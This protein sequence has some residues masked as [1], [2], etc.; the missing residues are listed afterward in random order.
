MKISLIWKRLLA[1]LLTMALI[2]AQTGA[3]IAVS[4]EGSPALGGET[5]EPPV[6][7]TEVPQPS[8]PLES[9]A[10]TEEVP[11]QGGLD[12]EVV[13]RPILPTGEPSGPEETSVPE[14]V[15][16]PDPVLPQETTAPAPEEV[17]PETETM[18]EIVERPLLPQGT[19]E[20]AVL[21]DGELLPQVG[22]T[23]SQLFYR[24]G[25][26]VD[27]ELIPYDEYGSRYIQLNDL[28]EDF[29][30]ET[31]ESTDKVLNEEYPSHIRYGYRKYDSCDGPGWEQYNTVPYTEEN[32]SWS[33]FCIFPS[34]ETMGRVPDQEFEGWYLYPAGSAPSKDKGSSEDIRSWRYDK[35]M[36]PLAGILQDYGPGDPRYSELYEK[37][38][39]FNQYS[40]RPYSD[41][42]GYW[43]GG[44]YDFYADHGYGTNTGEISYEETPVSIVG[45][46]VPS[47]QS[48]AAEK[49]G[50]ILKAAGT[51]AALPLYGDDIS[52]KVSPKAVAFSPEKTEYWLRVAADV[53]AL[54]L[55]FNSYELYY[56]YHQAPEGKTSPVTVTNTFGETVDAYTEDLSQRLLPEPI[57]YSYKGGTF[58][59][60]GNSI[61]DPAHSEWNVKGITLTQSAG[62]GSLYNDIQVTVTSPS[63]E[64]E[65]TYTFHVQR[66][67][68]PT[69][70]RAPGNTPAGM[71]Q[72]DVGNNWGVTPEE[73]RSNK[74]RARKFFEEHRTFDF[75]SSD[76]MYPRDFEHNQGGSIFRGIYTR[77]AWPSLPA[78]MD[79][80]LDPT[81][82]VVYQDAAFLDPG[83]TVTD[84]E[85]NQITLSGGNVTRTLRLREQVGGLSISGVGEG[86]GVTVDISGTVSAAGGC[87]QIDLRGRNILP[88]IYTMEYAYTDPISGKTYDSTGNG[89][90]TTAGAAGKN[91]FARTVVVLPIPGDVDMDGA[92]TSADAVIL[93]R[94]VGT[95]TAGRVTLNGRDLTTDKVAALFAYRVCDQDQNG[96]L[97]DSDVSLLEQLPSPKQSDLSK[98]DYYYIPLPTGEAEEHYSRQPLVTQGAG[99]DKA[100]ISMEYLGKEQGVRS[101]VGYYNNPS[102]PWS[103]GSTE[104]QGVTLNDTFWLGIKLTDGN[105]STGL[106]QNVQTFTFSLTYDAKYVEPA[107]VLSQADWGK[108]DNDLARWNDTVTY[109]N[110]GA[111]SGGRT[112][113]GNGYSYRL[114][115]AADRERPFTTHYSKAI[116][117]LEENAGVTSELRE[118]VFSVELSNESMEGITLSK[119]GSVWLFAVPF[120]LVKHPF[121]QEKARLVEVGAGMDGFTVVGKQTTTLLS[122]IVP[123]TDVIE[124]EKVIPSAAYNNVRDDIFGDS[125][126]NLRKGVAY[127]SAGAEIPLGEDKTE[128]NL[129]YNEVELGTSS[130]TQGMYSTEFSARGGWASRSG[131][132]VNFP[133]LQDT[134]VSGMPKGLEYTGFEIKG[135]PQEAGVFEFYIGETPYRLVIDKAPLRFWADNQVSYYGQSEFRG[136]QAPEFTFS[137]KV[138]D[139]KSIDRERAEKNE[140][141]LLDGVGAHLK[142]LLADEEVYNK[143]NPDGPKFTAVA[144][145]AGTPVAKTTNV[146]TYTITCPLRP[147][148]A[149]YEFQY[150]PSAAPGGYCRL[151]ILARPY[152]VSRIA[153][154][155]VGN[156]YTDETGVLINKK[157]KLE[158]GR[159]GSSVSAE[160]SVE[161]PHSNTDPEGYYDSLPLTQDKDYLNGVLV[162]GDSIGITYEATYVR[163]AL[164]MSSTGGQF[165]TL[166][167]G[168]NSEERNIRVS[169][170]RMENAGGTNYRLVSITPVEPQAPGVVGTVTRRNVKEL[171]IEQLPPMNYQYGGRLTNSNELQF[172]LEIEG[173]GR[174]GLYGYTDT[175]QKELGISITWALPE[176]REAYLHPE[177]YPDYTFDGTGGEKRWSLTGW[178]TM[179]GEKGFDSVPFATKQLFDMSYNGRYLCMS[180]HTADSSGQAVMVRRY[181]EIPLTVTPLT[182]T[183]TADSAQ[184]YYGEE[185]GVLTFTYRP[186]QLASCDSAGRKLTG[187]GEELAE[188]LDGQNY[189]APTLKAVDSIAAQNELKRTDDQGISYAVIIYGAKC[190]NY[191]FEYVFNQGGGSEIREDMGASNF[192]ILR[193]P[194]VVDAVTKTEPLVTIYADTHKIT[195]ENQEL[196]KDDVVI[197]LP[198]HT[199]TTTEYYPRGGMGGSQ[200]FREQV[201]YAEGSSP[202][203]EGDDLSFV[204]TATVVSTDGQNYVKYRNFANGYFNMDSGLDETYGGKEY[205]VQVSNLRLTGEKAG[206]YI[207]VFRDNNAAIQSLPSASETTVVPGIEPE[208]SA[209]QIYYVPKTQE[210]GTLE[211]GHIS[212]AR[213]VL[214]PIESIEILTPGKL[215]YTYG[216]IYR[217]DSQQ[218]LAMQI[219]I[220]YT[221]NEPEDTIAGNPTEGYV[222]MAISRYE[223]T[224][225]YTTFDDRSLVIYW[226]QGEDTSENRE[227]AIQNGQVLKYQEALLVDPH[228][229]AKLF[230]TGKRGAQTNLVVSEASK[231]TL[232]VSPKTLTL[233]A[234]DQSRSYGEPNGAFSFTFNKDQLAAKDQEKLNGY[235]GAMDENAL[236]YLAKN[237]QLAYTPPTISTTAVQGSPVL[238]NG[239]G[240]YRGYPI[241]I[242]GGGLSNYSFEYKPGNLYIYPRMI[243]IG[244]F[245]SSGDKPIYTIFA[246]MQA[247]LFTTSVT[248]K[249]SADQPSAQMLLPNGNQGYT[250]PDG[251]RLP[252]SGNALYGDDTLTLTVQVEF[253]KMTEDQLQGQNGQAVEARVVS[254]KLEPG[255][256]SENYILEQA[257]GNAAGLP[258][259]AKGKVELRSILGI[260][261]T[262]PSKLEY[263]YGEE[264][265]LTDLVV[266]IHYN[267]L[268]GESGQSL[269]VRFLSTEQFASNGL[270]VNYYPSN[271]LPSDLKSIKDTYPKASTGD[272]LTIAPTHETQG[273]SLDKQFSAN[274][275]YLVIT[276]L[277]NEAQDASAVIVGKPIKVNPLALSFELT[278][279]DKTY[280]DT[281][282]A[283]GTLTLTNV[284]R[285]SGVVD[286]VYPVTGAA[287]EKNWN[288][289]AGG[290]KTFNEHVDRNG[291]SFCTGTYRPAGPAPLGENYPL[292][293]P[294][295]YV[296]Q[297]PNTLTFTFVDSNVRYKDQAAAAE[298]R[299]GELEKVDVE[300]RGILLAGPDAP[301]YT[302]AGVPFGSMA[303]VTRANADRV[304]GYMGKAVP[305]ATIHKRN[306]DKLN[307]EFTAMPKVILPLVELD[308]HTNVVRVA[309]DRAL[310][311]IPGAATDTHTKPEDLHYE[312]ALQYNGST[313]DRAAIGQW[314]GVDGGSMWD[315]A[316]F[317]G[318][319]TVRLDMSELLLGGYVPKE[320]DIPQVGEDEEGKGQVYR[321]S[322]EDDGFRLDPTAYPGS[323]AE[324]W[325]GYSLYTTDRT[326]LERGMVY[327]PL[328]RVA[329][330]HNYNPSP[331]ISSVEGYTPELVQETQDALIL[332]ENTVGN[333]TD[334]EQAKEWMNGVARK[335]LAELEETFAEAGRVADQEMDQMADE[336]GSQTEWTDRAPAPAVRTYRQRIETISMEELQ[337][338]G[339]GPGDQIF[340]VPTLEAV[341]FTDVWDYP[342]RE[343]LD[344]VLHNSD[345][346]RYRGY[347][348]DK[349]YSA[350][351]D[352]EKAE[353]PISLA[354]ELLIPIKRKEDG[355]EID[356]VLTVNVNH[357]AQ[358]YVDVSSSSGGYFVTQVEGISIDS[359]DFTVVLGEEPRKLTVTIYPEES[360]NRSIRWSSS[361]P[362]VVKV[363]R[364]GTV[365]FVGLGRAV[366]T[367]TSVDGPS[368]SITVT[369]VEELKQT[370]YPNS[371]FDFQK[372]DAFFDL[373]ED[374]FFGPEL[375][376]TRGEVAMLLAKFYVENPNWTRTGPKDFPDLTGEEEYAEAAR[377]LGSV[378]VM[379][380]LPSGIFGGE[381]YMTRAEFVAMLVRM[382]GIEVPDTTGQKHA[383]LD[384]FED[385]TG[386][387]GTWAYSEIDALSKVEG[388]LQ[389]VG[390][391]YF[392]PRRNITRAEAVTFLSRLLQ[393]SDV[394]EKDLLI[395]SDVGEDHWARKPIL[396][397]VNRG[398]IPDQEKV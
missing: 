344:A 113:W 185:N 337:S 174:D 33:T 233:T 366:I 317:F 57:E 61:E 24:L 161:L 386:V 314:A 76:R 182:L 290:A 240:G 154:T 160:F 133:I 74:D 239:Q 362:T 367:A 356:D 112:V 152:L 333:P 228:N 300:V 150:T 52:G 266:T 151:T 60:P 379:T 327:L 360:T 27:F 42:G 126:W 395:P 83:V 92:V 158:T 139:I 281:T 265:D 378:G 358:I 392:A 177:E 210:G 222:T 128:I 272:H 87:D 136:N 165:F 153:P 127:A 329:E 81:A 271:T 147:E 6:Q 124:R 243:K 89:F 178:E 397:A 277:R 223:G 156:I 62:T 176:E 318:G 95:N 107:I 313:E 170:V 322:G 184:R 304:E 389:G 209:D 219:K 73:I 143:K 10:P 164:D 111:G 105:K 71:I 119:E 355:Q 40:D 341:W 171:R 59:R 169:N 283:A 279:E 47:S 260:E 22:R 388:V 79:I 256:G 276:A 273:L 15:E 29:T 347:A 19:P 346:V 202:I 100:V 192:S 54:D 398:I 118:L 200:P 58:T 28:G 46:W 80:D 248:T 288:T 235:S 132:R 21:L 229:G 255:L 204:Y 90:V 77:I 144:N 302:I 286:M 311:T 325:P 309:F 98:S 252:V 257:Y 125:T 306:R 146:G 253:D 53:T 109:Y 382:M 70:T 368:D 299:Y 168:S 384:T 135:T 263:T 179:V 391:G 20:N 285:G 55:V 297:R 215:T 264:L 194:I 312:Y 7:G 241:T 225:T 104:E 352:F 13:E 211:N 142:D 17:S 25:Y 212:K 370:Q 213:V 207:L 275:K 51:D 332:L 64:E 247:Q 349:W 350:P 224:E 284:Y 381:R 102:G 56:D 121:G 238:S 5:Q 66:L 123:L 2:W 31:R 140:N 32:G 203:L 120:T 372:A 330:S 101:D 172:F 383:F 376:M 351:L 305:G 173:G 345:P 363:D 375:E 157:A 373:D 342:K 371:I 331:A 385:T 226:M 114:T 316:V 295:G 287:Y 72:R 394:L 234:K 254:A 359:G 93:E 96:K 270:Y 26:G 12:V 159:D 396:R 49:D 245:D 303:E 236:Q 106:N 323:P 250:L 237:R 374:L 188:I 94:N 321:W 214:R 280:D 43:D 141:I 232:K 328:V 180:I 307:V 88:G 319:E 291:Y 115:Q 9:P 116:T 78:E 134:E 274:G 189:T 68:E 353:V 162:P 293:R 82:I 365:T 278:A 37:V 216:E 131:E 258:Q 45:R 190:D 338:E 377:L 145:A 14:E 181:S 39:G 175:T 262:G 205:P 163:T 292:S 86:L 197:A 3:V 267:I 244:G 167:E 335:V 208:R 336:G 63:G 99:G 110:M 361:D 340:L 122:S 84:S 65:T 242:S 261:I 137:Y 91:A 130:R 249:A 230:I 354:T 294:E 198:K 364:S 186:E 108:Q 191:K 380:G 221:R 227:L 97:S 149:N 348:W 268:G 269:P 301:N 220:S 206:N 129:I 393:F 103:G 48:K 298:E 11:G 38:D 8:Q 324:P 35:T 315:D 117:P 308:V 217:P 1:L 387:E 155:N 339:A 199:E 23:A 369:V 196:T 320:E 310:S 30:A 282:E 138:E 343:I 187:K 148:S 390:E 44:E 16:T 251:T 50:A 36:I 289:L 85:G 41:L 193:R 357:S 218:G 166:A 69:L 34:Q 67:T 334:H 259:S 75:E 183:L 4:L 201:G 246:S 296:Y 195:L 326:A 231:N 18:P